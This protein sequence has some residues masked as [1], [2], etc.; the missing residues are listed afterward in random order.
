MASPQKKIQV[1]EEEGILEQK[2]TVVK[3]TKEV[4]VSKFPVGSKRYNEDL[5]KWNLEHPVA[6]EEVPI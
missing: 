2:P 3:E 6:P 4:F 1:K 5:A